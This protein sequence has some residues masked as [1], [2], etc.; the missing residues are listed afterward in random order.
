MNLE[1]LIQTVRTNK[2]PRIVLHGVHGVGK[3]TWAANA[4]SPIFLITEDGLTSIDVPH[5]PLC[6]TLDEVFDY[7][8]ILIKEE[9]EYKTFVLDTA[10]WLEK[11]I[12]NNICE[13]ASMDNIESFG[14]ARGYTIAMK[15]WDRLYKGLELLRDKGMATVILAHNEI[16]PY[17]PPDGDPYDRYQIK[18]HK[19]AATK[20][21]EW[22]D[23]VL[24][25]NFQVYVDT[26]K[27]KKVGKAARGEAQRVIHTTSCPAWKAKTRYKLPD[28]LTM[29]F[30]QL[31]E[32]IKNG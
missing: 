26:E 9:H 15:E 25:A 8:G 11:I 22:A 10:D 30:N 18:L 2:P 14:Y 1:T 23:I 5:F 3:S 28:T 19:H 27:G 31:L 7:M 6:T 21:E 4:P 12:W 29:D 17:N 13:K 20:L 24:F 16:K 32:A